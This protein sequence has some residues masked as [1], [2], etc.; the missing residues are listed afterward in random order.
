MF[1]LKLMADMR[2]FF[3][4]PE[5]EKLVYEKLRSHFLSE[6]NKMCPKYSI[7]QFGDGDFIDG[8]D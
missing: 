7:S 4:K 5:I 8:G 6:F 2:K 1:D 3:F